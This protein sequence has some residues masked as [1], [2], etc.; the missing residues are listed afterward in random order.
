MSYL[1]SL[2]LL[3]VLIP[4]ALLDVLHYFAGFAGCADSA[5]FARRTALF[6]WL[7]WVY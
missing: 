5:G 1:I 6:R 3:D 4:L 2:A 7:C